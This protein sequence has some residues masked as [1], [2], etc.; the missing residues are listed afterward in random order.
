MHFDGFT[1]DYPDDYDVLEPKQVQVWE[2]SINSVKQPA[3]KDIEMVL[4]ASFV[5]Y[6]DGKPKK[7]SVECFLLSRLKPTPEAWLR[8]KQ[9]ESIEQASVSP[10]K[11]KR[12]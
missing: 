8:Q 3:D 9:M 6:V 11:D 2:L 10:R 7:C 1:A 5:A 4:D 12:P